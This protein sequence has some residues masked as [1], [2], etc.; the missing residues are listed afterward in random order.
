L[1][2]SKGKSTLYDINKV[3]GGG[4][5]RKWQNKVETPKDKRPIHQK[6]ITGGFTQACLP[7][8]SSRAINRPQI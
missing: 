7:L 3:G 6:G 8:D 2:S 5:R 1:R 4:E